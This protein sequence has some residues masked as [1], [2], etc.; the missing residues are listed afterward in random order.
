MGATCGYHRYSLFQRQRT[1]GP[2][3][4]D[5]THAVANNGS[6][7]YAPCPQHLRDSDLDCKQCG[8]RD[9]GESHAVAVLVGLQALDQGKISVPLEQFVDLL[10]PLTEHRIGL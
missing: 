10:H 6:R 3:C 8:L 1:T 9:L 2:R 7:H 5:L 4:T